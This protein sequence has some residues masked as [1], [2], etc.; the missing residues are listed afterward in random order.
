M[1]LHADGPGSGDKGTS[2]GQPSHAAVSRRTWMAGYAALAL[3]A[4][5]IGVWGGTA[6]LSGAV[7][8]SGQFVVDGN[9][10]KVQHQTGGVVG[11]LRVREGDRVEAGDLLIRLDA[12]V[13]RANL[14]IIVRQ[15]DEFAARSARL[16]A[17]RDQAASLTMPERLASRLDEPDVAQLI[18]AEERLFTARA[19]ARD[20]LRAQ[21][22]RRIGQLRSE[23]EGLIEQ[24]SAKLREAEL[25]K[26]ELTGVR[27]LFRQ[28]LVQITRLSQLE[29]EAASL[30][31]QK[32]QF[33]AQIAQSEGRIAETELQIL[34]LNEDLRA[35]VMKELR[36]IQG[37]TGELNERRFAAEDQLKRIDVRAPVAGYVHQM[38]VH[39]VGGVISPAEP[40]MLIV[41]SGDDLSLEAR[42][43]T[44][45]YDQVRLGQEVTV[46]L[47]AFNQRTTPEL[48]GLVT[49]MSPDV[50][51]EAQTGMV[52]YTIRV[53]IAPEQLAQIAPLK[54]S[55]GMQSDAY[56]QTGD[57]TPFS[58]LLRP[59]ADQFSKAFR[60][61]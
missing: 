61:R 9:V 14:Q 37:R 42:V 4:G 25:I 2:P 53:G 54:V 60:E 52:Y 19:T 44:S 1:I 27:E 5:T 59:V 38:Q 48:R 43:T 56:L 30:D 45:D 34:Q 55:A 3:F 15:L 50:T 36:E 12:T 28:N 8:A 57:R 18:M 23:I 13:A 6:A 31:G 16:E 11:E 58:Y 51:R 20:G 21:L 29:R 46:K 47:H 17:E 41:P 22:S 49:R 33:T 24:R 26:R 7:I 39:T 40:A 32:G 35:E 10:K